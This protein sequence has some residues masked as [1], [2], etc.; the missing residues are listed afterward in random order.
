MASEILGIF[1]GD[2][3]IR[4]AIIEAIN[5]L[6]R[7]PYLLDYVFASLP[8]DTLT[9]KEYGAQDVAKAKDWFQKTN[10]FTYLSININEVK[11]PCISINLVSSTEEENTFSDT[12]YQPT[13]DVDRDWPLLAG[14]LTPS[15]YNSVNGTI[16]FTE[17]SLKGLVLVSGMI[18]VTNTGQAY[19]VLEV[20]DNVTTVVIESG[21]ILDLEDVQVRAA[22]PAYVARVESAGYRE[23]YSL[24]CHV[25][26]EAIHLIYLHSILIFALHRYRETLLEGRGFERS[27][28]TS[29][30]LRRDDS[31]LPEFMYDRYVQLTGYVR[32]SWPK[33]IARKME[34][35]DTR[36]VFSDD[37]VVV[38][39]FAAD[40]STEVEIAI[41]GV[42][43]LTVY[44]G[45]ATQPGSVDAAFVIGLDSAY[46]TNKRQATLEFTAGA[47]EYCWIAIPTSFGGTI[48]DFV[49]EDT[50][51]DVEMTKYGPVLVAGVYLNVFRSNQANLG[52]LRILIA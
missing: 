24:G 45:V 44:Y 49:D 6:R 1:Q 39:V 31:N 50:A 33:A 15:T 14:P 18:I 16:V 13:E 34:S 51:S 5:D 41:A 48:S 17:A 42:P 28:I 8:V 10:V 35:M 43:D 20:P 4:T 52:E 40:N 30:D 47:L 21:H 36:L 25:D 26:S 12:H 19:P 32:Q 9:A 29:T 11:F 38:D 2:L 3:I 27:S 22:R 37:K 23:V 46:R 7:N